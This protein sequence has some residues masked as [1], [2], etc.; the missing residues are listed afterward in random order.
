MHCEKIIHHFLTI[1]IVLINNYA[2]KLM[3]TSHFVYAACLSQTV[4]V[5]RS[6]EH[7]VGTQL[8]LWKI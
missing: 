7:Q 6:V 5:A 3:M 2:G 8:M 4:T 1:N